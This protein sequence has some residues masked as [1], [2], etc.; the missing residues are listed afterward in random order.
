MSQ[1]ATLKEVARIARVSAQTVSRVVNK[2]PDVAEETR[3]RVQQVIDELGYQPNTI[4]RSL[5]TRLSRT[6]GVVA[7]GLEYYGPSTILIGIQQEAESLGYSLNLIL[8]PDPSKED[9]SQI[10]NEFNGRQVDGIIWA[11]PPVGQNRLRFLA[12]RLSQAPPTIFLNQPDPAFSVISI[13]N[14][15]GARLAVK[16]LIQQGYR[17]IAIVSGPSQWWESSERVQGW[18]QALAEEGLQADLRLCYE[19]DW[20]AASGEQAFHELL[21]RGLPMDAVFASND[22]MALGVIRAAHSRAFRLPDQ[23]GVI[24]YDDYPDSA[25]FLPALSTIRQPLREAGA[26]AVREL[27]QM[28]REQKE[29]PAEYEVKTMI[30]QP[31]L[32]VRESTNRNPSQT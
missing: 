22:Q 29:N 2:R 18:K 32:V 12:P 11:V 14:R 26:S 5:I 7:A 4:A 20:T 8:T 16:H 28:I 13:D 31:R 15:Q 21:S 17:H 19:G 6:L 25:Y 27:V 30:L 23:I 24:G 10:V 3:T 1:K 9:F